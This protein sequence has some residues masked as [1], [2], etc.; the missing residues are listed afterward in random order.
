MHQETVSVGDLSLTLETGQL[1]RQAAGAV[2]VRERGSFLLGTLTRGPSSGHGAMLTVDFQER[3][4]ASSGGRNLG[5]RD[6]RP[7]DAQ[8]LTARLIDRAVRPLLPTAHGEEFH[9]VVTVFSAE[10]RA[11][12]ES[13][14]VIAALAAVHV[15]DLPLPQASPGAG[16]RLCRIDGALRALPPPSERGAADLDLMIAASPEGLLALDGRAQEIPEAQLGEIVGQAVA[17]MTPL[18]AALDRLRQAVN[19]QPR[20]LLPAAAPVDPAVLAAVADLASGSVDEALAQA[21]ASGR[22]AALSAVERDT[23]EL[24]QDVA[25]DAALRAAFRALLQRRLRARAL[26]G[27]QRSGGRGPDEVRPISA[28]CGLLEAHHGS[29]LFTRGQTQVL[30]VTTLAPDH[31]QAQEANYQRDSERLILHYHFPPYAVGEARPLRAPTRREMGHGNLARMA[32]WAVLPESF[33]YQMRIIADVLEADG[34]SSM[35]TV[36]AGVLAL[37]QAGV[38]LRAPVAGVAMGL[39]RDGD[40]RCLLTDIT[41][42]EDAFGELDLKVA[43][44]ADGVTALQMDLKGAAVPLVLL[45]EL[46]ERAQAARRQILAAMADAQGDAARRGLPAKVPHSATL[47]IRPAYIGRLIGPG[48]K[49]IQE[50]RTE[51]RTSVEV[52]DDGRVVILGKDPE[53]VAAARR[54]IE[55]LTLELRQQGLYVATVASLQTYGAMVSIGDHRGLV[56]VTE[57]AEPAPAAAADVCQVGQEMLVRVLGVD[58]K[59]RLR[60]SRKAAAGAERTEALNI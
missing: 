57:L 42:H 30:A 43:G 60:M 56:H 53:R 35:A 59:G 11:D 6:G 47:D 45:G 25:K 38:P 26:D 12:L 52:S 16:L 3:A 48:G 50:I 8:I 23:L 37:Q 44:T 20:P 27:G 10:S 33:P 49:N 14:G 18:W 22:R 17:L 2:V 9:V 39:V 54:R 34:S 36:C 46:L 58:E 41:E 51:T 29:A 55:L 21:T 19:P 28:A 32:L 15:S 24:A 13:L 40:R 5:R 7:T 1:A 31:A 4:P